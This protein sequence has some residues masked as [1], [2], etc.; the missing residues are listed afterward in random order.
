MKKPLLLSTLALG[1]SAW[2][3]ACVGDSPAV[4][5]PTPDSGGTPDTS[6]TP[7]SSP[8]ADAGADAPAPPCDL[9]K[10][11]GII[12][13]VT[14][15]NDPSSNGGSAHLTVD[16]LTVF[17]GTDRPN[18]DLHIKL[19]KS[20]RAQVTDTWPAPTLMPNINNGIGTFF[21]NTDAVMTSDGKTLYYTVGAPFAQQIYKST[22]TDVSTDFPVGAPE[23]ALRPTDPGD[24]GAIAGFTIYLMPDDK[25]MYYSA[26][27]FKNPDL[28]VAA[29]SSGGWSTPTPLTSI[30]STQVEQYVAVTTDELT[31]Y[32]GSSRDTG[33]P[34]YHKIYMATRATKS[35]DF[36][37]L[38]AVAELNSSGA[39]ID[40]GPSYIS[41]DGCT[42]WITNT[43]TGKNQIY[44]ATKP[45]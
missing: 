38:A 19:W 8:A 42:I 45:K 33:D 41:P 40:Q 28:Y 24:A 43:T 39:T 37:N 31:I 1:A 12:T 6:T 30:N 44:T 20:T 2:I 18:G 10:P 13:P 32:F 16:Q 27:D 36:G 4:V 29:F 22:R 25:T 11:F 14:E 26:G 23:T 15:L 21:W 17:T 3:A 9:T 34:R 35:A 7:D 5:N